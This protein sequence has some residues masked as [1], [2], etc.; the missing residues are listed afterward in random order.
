MMMMPAMMTMM[1]M[2][3]MVTMANLIPVS[4]TVHLSVTILPTGDQITV[5]IR[6][7]ESKSLEV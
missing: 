1:I 5:T 3:M 2:M 7:V 6:A 4:A